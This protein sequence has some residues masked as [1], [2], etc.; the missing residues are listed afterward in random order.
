MATNPVSRKWIFEEYL[1]YEEETGI[2]P[3]EAFAIQKALRDE[4]REAYDTT[5]TE[6]EAAQRFVNLYVC[7]V[8]DVNVFC[9]NLDR[10]QER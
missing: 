10:H 9:Q 3:E 1:A 2:V 6:R 7:E 5:P 8:F 4:P